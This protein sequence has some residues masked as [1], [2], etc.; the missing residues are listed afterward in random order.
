MV[1]RIGTWQPRVPSP[2]R[3]PM[4][5]N[6]DEQSTFGER[7][8]DAVA[9]FGGAWSFIPFAIGLIVYLGVNVTLGGPA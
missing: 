4:P 3:S 1:A 2:Q 9:R 7:I 5:C 6:A 8:A